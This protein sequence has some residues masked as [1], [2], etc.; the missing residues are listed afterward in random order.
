MTL[1]EL[2]KVPSKEFTDRFGTFRVAAQREPIAITSHGTV[3]AVLISAHDFVEYERLKR[4]DTR[5][6]LHP[7]EL[8]D[9]LKAELEKGYQGRKTPEL[10]HLVE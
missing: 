4:Y 9:E 1:D 5:V 10:D 3:S 2:R 7:S 8:D 6:A